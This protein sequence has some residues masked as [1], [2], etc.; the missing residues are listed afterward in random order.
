MLLHTICTGRF[1]V[2]TL[3]FIVE[4][5]L[6]IVHPLWD[7]H[8]RLQTTAADCFQLACIR[9]LHPTSFC[10]NSHDYP[11]FQR[12]S[13]CASG[14]TWGEPRA[15]SAR[16]KVHVH[17]S[18][19]FSAVVWLL[20]PL[21]LGS[22][23]RD[24]SSD[25]V[26]FLRNHP[27]FLPGPRGLSW[28]HAPTLS[29]PWTSIQCPLCFGNSSRSLPPKGGHSCVRIDVPSSTVPQG[30]LSSP[31]SSS[32]YLLPLPS[33]GSPVRRGAVEMGG[34]RD[35]VRDHRSTGHDRNAS[36]PSE[37]RPVSFAPSIRALGTLP[38]VRVPPATFL[39]PLSTVRSS[40]ESPHP[41]S[42]AI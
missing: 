29:T 32:K 24:L 38:S 22:R 21:F 36:P 25:H 3:A 27:P 18:V 8:G 7:P 2:S 14:A 26:T 11:S 35:H 9:V 40:P 33:P 5:V 4:L 37:N 16:R 28:R 13:G 12:I 1:P 39:G 20:Q 19:D 23:I 31:P 6:H 30:L 42:W 17:V 34:T 10:R 15:V 41:A